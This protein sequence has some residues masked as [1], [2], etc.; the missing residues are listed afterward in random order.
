[1]RTLR[2][3]AHV[4]TWPFIVIGTSAGFALGFELG[5]AEV[6]LALVPLLAFVLLFALEFGLPERSG[7]GSWRDP[8][9]WNDIT[10]NIVGQGGGNALGQASFVFGSALLAGEISARWGGNLWPAEWPFWL[11]VPLLIFLADGL[12]YLRHRLEHSVAWLW[13]IHALHHDIDRLNIIKSGRGHVLD[14]LFRNLVCYAPLALVGV[15][16]EVLLTYAAAVT[17]FGP[18]AHANVSVWVPRF[19]H[20]WVLTPQVHRIHHARALALSCSNYANVFP[21]WDI[22][23]GTF[24][25]PEA[26]PSFDYGIEDGHQPADF[27]GQVLDPFAQWRRTTDATRARVPA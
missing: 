26:H 4:M 22:L 8:Q 23:F 6:S 1:M 15:P 21:I 17:V 16:R 2:A 5:F 18:V 24:E 13:P 11:Q 25:H 20:R 3:I 9:A 7:A 14:M 27:A 12:D 19:L 10:H